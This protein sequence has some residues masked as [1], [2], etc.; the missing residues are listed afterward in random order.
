MF[1]AEVNEHLLWEVVK[2]QQAKKRAGTHS[3]KTVAE[4]RGSNKKPYR[5]KG[6]GN[7]RQGWSSFHRR[8]GGGG[9]ALGEPRDLV[10][11]PRR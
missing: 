7:A 11:A 2:W 1:D 4:V 6:T 9:C 3:T 5:Q 10:G 8:P